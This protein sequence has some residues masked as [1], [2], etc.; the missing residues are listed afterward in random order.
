MRVVILMKLLLGGLTFGISAQAEEPNPQ[1]VLNEARDLARQGKYPE[2]LEK[3]L[4][5]HKNALAIQPSFSAVRLSFA[6]SAWADLGKKYP[7]AREALINIR[8]E[9]VK[10][11]EAGNGSF[12]LV[13]EITSINSYLEDRPATVALFKVVLNRQPDL[14]GQFYLAAEEDL[15]TAHEYAICSQFIPDSARRLDALVHLREMQGQMAK[16]VPDMQL[17]ADR[18]FV[19]SIRLIVDI[20]VHSGRKVEAN[21]VQT[22]ALTVLD[23]PSIRSAVDEA[24]RGPVSP[25]EAAVRAA[26]NEFAAACEAGN[27]VALAVLLTTD[28][29]GFGTDGT[30][31]T[32]RDDLARSLAE[33]AARKPGRRSIPVESVR[34]LGSDLALVDGRAERVGAAPPAHRISLILRRDQAG[35]K[36]SALRP[37]PAVN[38]ADP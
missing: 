35:W 12:E 15:V 5:F 14:A 21:E 24:T 19:A 9:D 38:P 18:S 3:H 37:G 25:E 13:Q 2:A 6:L 26:V 28:V 8:D 1:Q 4:W 33:A 7:K 32:G 11:V 34:F 17:V 31:R 30:R 16:T 27:P 22:R 36:V 23:A 10:T 29:D 20:L